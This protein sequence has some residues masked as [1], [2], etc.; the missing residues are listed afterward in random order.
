MLITLLKTYD[1]ILPLIGNSTVIISCDGCRE[2]YFPE[3]EV[4]AMHSKL[5]VSGTALAVVATDYVCNSENFELYLQKNMSAIEASDTLLV[6][7]CGVGV[8]SIADRFSDKPVFAG[9]DTYPLPGCQGVTPLEF[10]CVECGNCHLNDT[11]GI[12]PITTC[13]KSLV[14]GQ[15]GGAK[16]GKCEVDKEFECGW[17]LIYRRLK[18]LKR[19]TALS[20]PTKIRN[21]QGF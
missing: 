20:G 12:C 7:S 13:S 21:F 19:L 15:C 8:Q 3:K 2:V 18:E 11:G 1:D 17:E 9:C 10:D 16:S 6:F 4:I 5:L 14:N